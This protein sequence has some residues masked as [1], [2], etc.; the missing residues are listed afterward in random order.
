M[1]KHE[2]VYF[3]YEKLEEFHAGMWEDPGAGTAHE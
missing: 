2:R 3:H 1:A